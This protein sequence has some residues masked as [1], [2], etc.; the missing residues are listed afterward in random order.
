MLAFSL[1]LEINRS[2]KKKK[3][4]YP[5]LPMNSIKKNLSPAIEKRNEN[6][7]RSRTL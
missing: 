2:L 4:Q 3:K 1:L 7:P 6:F 5:I